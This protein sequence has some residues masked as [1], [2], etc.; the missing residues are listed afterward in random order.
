MIIIFSTYFSIYIFSNTDTYLLV[1]INIH[2]YAI[3]IV[4][5]QLETCAFQIIRIKIYKFTFNKII[6]TIRLYS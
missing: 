4:D 1:L 3:A 6:D 2:E 5:I